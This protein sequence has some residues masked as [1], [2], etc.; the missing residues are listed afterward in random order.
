MQRLLAILS[1]R[2]SCE[3]RTG[4]GSEIVVYRHGGHHFTL[5]HHKVNTHVPAAVIRNL[6]QRVGISFDE[7]L[8][9]LDL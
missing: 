6:L 3:V 7:W 9:A 8:M 1:E 5:G 2:L 4:K